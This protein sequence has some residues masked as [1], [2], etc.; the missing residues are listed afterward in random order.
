MSVRRPAP[1]RSQQSSPA[2]SVVVTLRRIWTWR[3]AWTCTK[4]FSGVW[5]WAK[6]NAR[7]A[8]RL[9][10]TPPRPR[11]PRRH[12]PASGLLGRVTASRS[13]PRP[14]TPG[15]PRRAGRVG[16]AV[17]DRCRPRHPGGRGQDLQP[18]TR[19]PRSPA[20]CALVTVSSSP[21]SPS[22]TD[23]WGGPGAGLRPPGLTRRALQ[24]EGWSFGGRSQRAR[25][26]AVAGRLLKFR[27][28]W[29]T[30]RRIKSGGSYLSVLSFTCLYDVSDLIDSG[31]PGSRTLPAG[32]KVRAGR[33]AGQ[34]WKT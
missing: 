28:H 18:T 23:W 22:G 1:C 30:S 19:R 6:K 3:G 4:V 16:P 10:G 5:Q 15:H 34:A 20:S 29:Q 31:P 12:S 21:T 8:P 24:S 9:F 13:L 7:S 25:R 33:L 2:A 32:L 14:P 11:H 17:G 26:E 27:T